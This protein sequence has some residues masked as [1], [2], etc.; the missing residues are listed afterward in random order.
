MLINEDIDNKYFKKS[1]LMIY[2]VRL[3][4]EKPD[5]RSVEL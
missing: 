5:K 3:T 1:F 4:Q 2:N